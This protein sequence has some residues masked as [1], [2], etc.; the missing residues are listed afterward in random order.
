MEWPALPSYWLYPRAHLSAGRLLQKAAW[1]S[2]HW[3]VDQL[4][5]NCTYKPPSPIV[6]CWVTPPMELREGTH[7]HLLSLEQKC[8]FCL[9]FDLSFGKPPPGQSFPWRVVL[10]R[11]SQSNLKGW[12]RT[13]WVRPVRVVVSSLL[14]LHYLLC[15][16][17]LFFSRLLFCK[18]IKASFPLLFLGAALFPF[19]PQLP[20]VSSF[21]LQCGGGR[22][23]FK[24]KPGP[25]QIKHTP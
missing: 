21:Y 24:F 14:P 13:A 15:P 25:Q 17:D 20:A 10:R 11:C 3:G 9:S 1:P 19:H 5:P 7:P 8:H 12:D 4:Q 16:F 23:M 22:S 6:F 18:G 2:P